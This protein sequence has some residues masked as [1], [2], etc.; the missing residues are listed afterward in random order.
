M[1]DDW[2]RADGF[3]EEQIKAWCLCSSGEAPNEDC[4][5]HGRF[6]VEWSV[7]VREVTLLEEQFAPMGTEYTSEQDGRHEALES[8]EYELQS[9]RNYD[10]HYQ[11]DKRIEYRLRYRLLMPWKDANA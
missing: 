6:D 1:S 8:A 4:P 7:F 3:T 5:L 10:G 11:P 2:R 9:I